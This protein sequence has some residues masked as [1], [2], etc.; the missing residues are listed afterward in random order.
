MGRN[1]R[2]FTCCVGS[3]DVQISTIAR[4]GGEINL[5]PKDGEELLELRRSHLVGQHLVLG[6]LARCAIKKAKFGPGDD[7]L[8]LQA[9]NVRHERRV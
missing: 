4:V 3:S 9:K 8:F 1:I 6:R 5:A 2:P 7:Q